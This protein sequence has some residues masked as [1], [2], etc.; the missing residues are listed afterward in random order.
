LERRAKARVYPESARENVM[1][2]NTLLLIVIVILLLGG[3]Y[4]GR[5]RWF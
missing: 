1:D 4:Y 5:N 3:G 2:L